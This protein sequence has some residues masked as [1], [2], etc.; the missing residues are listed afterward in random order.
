[1]VGTRALHGLA[2]A[3]RRPPLPATALVALVLGASAPPLGAAGDAAL[4]TIDVPGGGQVVYGGIDGQ[5][6]PQGAMALMLRSVHGHFGDRPQV[7]KVFQVRG[8]DSYAAFFTLVARNQGAKPIA[9]EVIVDVPK[10]RQAAGALLYDEASRFTRSQPALL[11]TLG[12]AWKAA[13]PPGA[14]ASGAAAAPPAGLRL[15][16]AGDRSAYIGLPEGWQITGVAGGQVSVA[17][18]KGEMIGL[19]LIV[20]PIRDPTAAQ[21]QRLPPA[22]GAAPV[23]TCPA[24]GDL[25]RA[26]VCV[27]NQMREARKLPQ[28]S[29]GLADARPLPNPRGRPAIEASYEVDLHDGRGPREGSARVMALLTP[30]LPTWAMA[31]Q[32]ASVPKPLA[33]AEAGIVKAIIDSYRQDPKVID[34]ETKRKIDEIHAIGERS[35]LQAQAADQRRVADS[36]AF[37]AHLDDIDRQSKAMQNYTLDQTQIQDNERNGRATVSNGMAD[38]LVRADPDRYEIVPTA[39]FLRGVDY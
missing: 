11:R 4:T 39:N 37:S 14:E 12:E 9:G 32:S 36:R 27:V 29:F 5:Q 16:T 7:S 3:K 6:T 22:R 20:A 17:G 33:A 10:G 1:M 25:F 35:R 18:P 19:G 24:G 15:Q 38:A 13:D 23:I 30:G 34:G 26:Y 21:N 2:G 8:S 31:M 28:A